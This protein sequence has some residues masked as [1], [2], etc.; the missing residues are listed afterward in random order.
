[1]QVPQKPEQIRLTTFFEQHGDGW[2]V[3]AVHVSKSE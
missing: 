3:I 1:M 2:Q